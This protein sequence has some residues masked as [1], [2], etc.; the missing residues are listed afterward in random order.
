MENLYLCNLLP[1]TINTLIKITIW[2]EG[3]RERGERRG[4][5]ILYRRLAKSLFYKDL[6]CEKN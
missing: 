1:Y 4:E 2:R 3:G 5:E 6:F